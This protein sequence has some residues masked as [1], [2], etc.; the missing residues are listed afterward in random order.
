[1]RCSEVVSQSETQ[2]KKAE[3]WVKDFAQQY[4]ILDFNSFSLE[5]VVPLLEGQLQ[6]K[7][8]CARP[9]VR[10]EFGLANEWIDSIIS[11]RRVSENAEEKVRLAEKLLDLCVLRPTHCCD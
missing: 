1:M 7:L 4:R 5:K 8:I 2:G 6:Y 11:S 9:H 3:N 10:Q